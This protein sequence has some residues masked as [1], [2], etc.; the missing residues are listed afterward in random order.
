MA[1][2]IADPCRDHVAG[3]DPLPCDTPGGFRVVHLDE[4]GEVEQVVEPYCGHHAKMAVQQA[5]HGGATAVDYE[6][7]PTEE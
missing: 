1:G 7:I 3:T 4:A 2:L 6:P 5:E